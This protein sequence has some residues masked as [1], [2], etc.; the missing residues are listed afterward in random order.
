VLAFSVIVCLF[1]PF[2]SV[3]VAM[4]ESFETVRESERKM[5][6]SKWKGEKSS[7]SEIVPQELGMF[8][9]QAKEIKSN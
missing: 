6:T 4:S 7:S 8:S 3:I 9:K 1:K 5:C 2:G